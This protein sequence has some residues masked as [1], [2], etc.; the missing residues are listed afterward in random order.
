MGFN[1]GPIPIRLYGIIVMLGV[2]AGAFLAS[3]LARRRGED[4][5]VVWDGLIWVL[6]GGVLGARLWHILTPPPSMVEQGITT[7]YYLTHP[8]EAINLR[9]GGLGLPGAVFGGAL[10]LIIFGRRRRLNLGVWLDII[11]PALALGQAI[12]RW[13][14]FV[15]QELYGAPSDLPWAIRIDPEFRLPGYELEATYHPLFLYESLWN[16]A[17]VVL[18]IWLGE[19]FKDRL[20]A[21]DIFLIYLISY[22]V[23]RFLLEFLRLDAAQVAGI[24][25]NQTLMVVIGLASAGL[26]IWRHRE[27]RFRGKT[28]VKRTR[29]KKKAA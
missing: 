11:A 6:I 27:D 17:N 18:L 2:V 5:S 3:W 7:Y 22:P 8:L 10:A 4:S 14:N 20:K 16:L 1:I 26:L 25:A 28:E 21:G 19:R 29:R 13:G 24:N 23:G 12:G 9:A 15:N